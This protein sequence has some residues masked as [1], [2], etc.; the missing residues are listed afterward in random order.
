MN[1]FEKRDEKTTVADEFLWEW[2]ITRRHK[3]F[4]A[5]IL[6]GENPSAD[7]SNNLVSEMKIDMFL[8]EALLT[9]QLFHDALSTSYLR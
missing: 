9:V 1:N 7:T 8:F 4:T 3:Q 6:S 5:V 2:I